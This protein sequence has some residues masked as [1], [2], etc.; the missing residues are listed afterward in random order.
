M[1]AGIRHVR[2]DLG[3]DGTAFFGS[4]R[5]PERRTVQQE[6]DAALQRLTSR[7]VRLAFA[8]RTDRGVHAVGQVASGSLAW[9][10]D[11]ESLGFAGDSHTPGDV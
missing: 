9:R 2:I 1:A 10:R 8:G 7:D 3:Y 5:Q 6:I 4:Q 11:D